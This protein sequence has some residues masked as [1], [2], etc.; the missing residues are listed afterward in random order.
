MV[1]LKYSWDACQPEAPCCLRSSGVG[2]VDASLSSKPAYTL[3]LIHQWVSEPSCSPLL[4]SLKGYP[5]YL[6]AGLKSN[7]SPMDWSLP[8][9]SAGLTF[10]I[11]NPALSFR[12]NPKRA[13]CMIARYGI[14]ICPE[15]GVI[16]RLQGACLAPMRP[17]VYSLVLHKPSVVAHAKFQYLGGQKPARELG[18]DEIRVC[19]C[20]L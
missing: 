20:N 1:S 16:G 8:T 18:I 13:Q 15:T 19:V 14:C 2:L 9:L 17:R 6:T 5:Y 11:C 10:S 7:P 12:V 3:C 4:E